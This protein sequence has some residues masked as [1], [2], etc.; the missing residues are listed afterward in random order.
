MRCPKCQADTPRE[1]LCCP[2]CKRKTPKGR[3]LEQE[4]ESENKNRFL[5]I[6]AEHT[7]TMHHIP[8]WMTWSLVFLTMGVCVL[9][10]YLSFNYLNNPQPTAIPLHQ[11]ALDKLRIK[12]AN[13]SWMTVE[14]SLENEVEKS[15][16]AGR[17][18]ETEG[19]DVTPAEGGFSVSFTFQEKD[20]RKRSATWLVNPLSETYVP[21][22]DLASLIYSP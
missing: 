2:A 18:T 15:R 1:A 5:E 17:L 22:N 20:S 3:R 13:Q 9:G 19:W 14:E 21:Q 4:P 10:S 16:N 8:L 6:L 11:L 7:P 12:T